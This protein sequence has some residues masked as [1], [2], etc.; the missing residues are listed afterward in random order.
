MQG[1]RYLLVGRV[2]DEGPAGEDASGA[3]EESLQTALLLALLR[4][5]LLDRRQFEL[6]LEEIHAFS[7]RESIKKN[8]ASRRE[9]R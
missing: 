6:C 4:R 9:Q 7:E 5:G 8:L 3:F 1:R 2:P